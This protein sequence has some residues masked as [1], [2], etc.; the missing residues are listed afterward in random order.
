MVPFTYRYRVDEQIVIAKALRMTVPDL[1][2]HLPS[3]GYRLAA[4]HYPPKHS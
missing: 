4:L 2:W 3:R 1:V